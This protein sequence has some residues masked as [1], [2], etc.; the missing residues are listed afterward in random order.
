MRVGFASLRVTSC[1]IAS[2]ELRVYELGN[3]SQKVW[4][5]ELASW[6]KVWVIKPNFINFVE[7][8]INYFNFVRTGITKEIIDQIVKPPGL[9]GKLEKCCMEQSTGSHSLSP[10]LAIPFFPDIRL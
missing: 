7:I 6:Q 1:E 5:C 4:V 8:G 9:K 10:F 3:A 2:R